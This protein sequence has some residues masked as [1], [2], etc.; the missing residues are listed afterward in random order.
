MLTWV[1]LVF[2]AGGAD[3]IDVLFNI[4][5]TSQIWVFRFLVI[6]GPFAAAAIA[7]RVCVE[8]QRGE[9][10]EHE[11][12]AAEREGREASRR[13]RA[14]AAGQATAEPEPEPHAESKPVTARERA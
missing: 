2:V 10:A 7:W 12:E 1:V 13:R 4:S 9:R 8:L 11:R 5:Y 6:G 14:E 3:R